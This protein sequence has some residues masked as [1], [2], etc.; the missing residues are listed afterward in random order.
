MIW[1][2]LR[3]TPQKEF[4]FER[5]LE[6]EGMHP[7]VPIKYLAKR[8]GRHLLRRELVAYPQHPG[9]MFLRVDQGERMQWELVQRFDKLFRG[10]ITDSYG[11]PRAFTECEMIRICGQ[12]QRPYLISSR[13][14]KNRRRFQPNAEII[15]GPHQ[16]RLV[17]SSL[18]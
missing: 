6:I 17:A 16:G 18:A 3:V 1:Y 13:G 10:I 11:A 9:L 14:R 2:A 12:S 5:L 15:S 7:F 4:L 8:N